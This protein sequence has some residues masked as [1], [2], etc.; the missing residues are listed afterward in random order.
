[1]DGSL[2]SLGMEFRERSCWGRWDL[3]YWSVIVV[4]L[5]SASVSAS[6]DLVEKG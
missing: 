6:T 2:S 5:N 1:M 3:D 4:I